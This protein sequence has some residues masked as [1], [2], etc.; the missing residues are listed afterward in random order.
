VIGIRA[1]SGWAAVVAVAGNL[2][3][4][5][6][7]ARERVP[8]I[9]PGA[10]G[11]KQ[12]YHFAKGLSLKDAEAHLAHHAEEARRLAAEGL[13]AIRTRASAS[14]REIIGCAILTASGRPLP[15]LQEILASHAMIHTAEGEFFRNAFA[16]ACDQ[17]GIRTSKFRERELLAIASAELRLAPAKIKTRLASV[18]RS[19]GPPWAQDQK[20]AALAGFLLLR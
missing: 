8:L 3:S 16:D 4:P 10:R 1:H 19:V 20:S 13:K 17:L 5:E 6:I 9:D 18:G 12:P 7:L 2:E 14:G 15:T 11:A